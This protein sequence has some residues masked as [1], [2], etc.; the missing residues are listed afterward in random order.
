MITISLPFPLFYSIFL[1]FFLEVTSFCCRFF[2]C[3]SIPSDRIEDFLRTIEDRLRVP[4]FRGRGAMKVRLD[5]ALPIIVVPLGLCLATINF[6][7]T[8]LV[9]VTLP[10]A[11]LGFY[12]VW[13]RRTVKT[14]TKIFYSWGLT[15]VIQIYYTFEFI[16]V[17]FREILLW[18][19]LLLSSLFGL[20]LYAFYRCK[21]GPGVVQRTLSQ[22]FQ[23]A[24]R[25]GLVENY[26]WKR[27]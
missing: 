7:F 15:S 19:N 18:E 13:S 6:V 11:I 24:A 25:R 14:R 20:T 27:T 23:G 10:A 1:Q 16:V 5:I 2:K 26:A 4:G 8:V 3:Q 12:E 9:L 21:K 22:D 17:T